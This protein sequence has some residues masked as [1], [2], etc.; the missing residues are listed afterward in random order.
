MY[1]IK[2]A[3]FHKCY[4][5]YAEIEDSKWK[6]IAL[7]GRSNVGKSS[8][9]NYLLD[10]KK[11]AYI[12]STPGKTQTFNYYNIDNKFF[13]VDMPGFGYAKIS[14]SLREIWVEN[15]EKYLRY[16]KQMLTVFLL[17]DSRLTP[18]KK[19]L[20]MINMLGENQISFSIIFT[21]IDKPNKKELEQNISNYKTKLLE[22]WEVLPKMFLTS[23]FKKKG[24]EEVLDYIKEITSET[25]KER[26][27]NKL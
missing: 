6:E 10:R 11:L 4:G 15:I 16:R 8:L 27:V 25:H 2:T 22:T 23:S 3:E 17:I 18:Q 19:D 12:S 24:R 21:K 1:K 13:L 9:I 7:I 26:K 14:K 20:E 5:K